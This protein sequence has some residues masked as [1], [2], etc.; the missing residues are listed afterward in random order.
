MKTITYVVVDQNAKRSTFEA[1]S[2]ARTA[3]REIA[4]TGLAVYI[5]EVETRFLTGFSGW[6]VVTA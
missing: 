1:E 5:L 4:A 6:E 3:A 2:E